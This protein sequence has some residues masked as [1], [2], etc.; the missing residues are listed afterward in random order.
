MAPFVSP[1]AAPAAATNRIA[2]PL[3][4]PGEQPWWHDLHEMADGCQQ[5]GQ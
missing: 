3:A 1:A 5:Q 4:H 2:A